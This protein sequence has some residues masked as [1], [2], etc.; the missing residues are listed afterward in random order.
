[1]KKLMKVLYYLGSALSMGVGIWHFFVPHLYQWYD[2]LP[3]Q[4]ENLIVGIDYT[5]YFFSL[6]LTGLSLLLILSGKKAFAA[7]REIIVFYGFLVFVWLNR[8]L[9]TFVH[10]WP[11]EPVA[12]AA[13]GQQI[14]AITIFLLLAASFVY[15]IRKPRAQKGKAVK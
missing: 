13:H 5:N 2:Y 11:L 8:A 10:P 6:L 7:N 15:L 1:M 9:I 3:M 12:W 4:Y 14:A